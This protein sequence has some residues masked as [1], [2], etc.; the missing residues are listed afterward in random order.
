[1]T[2]HACEGSGRI[3]VGEYG[4]DCAAMHNGGR[5]PDPPGWEECGA[6]HGQRAPFYRCTHCEWLGTL[7]E[8]EDD[9]S[10]G[11]EATLCPECFSHI[12]PN[13]AEE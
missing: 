4:V 13:G 10:I 8:A 2:C 7:D 3:P 12:E 5:V 11:P 9:A 6:C 1:M